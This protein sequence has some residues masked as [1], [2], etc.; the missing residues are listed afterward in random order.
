MARRVEFEVNVD[1]A[2]LRQDMAQAT[3][4]V[5][6]LT[7][8]VDRLQAEFKEA[9]NN[10]RRLTRQLD[11]LE[12][13]G[14][15][16][17]NQYR[18]LNQ[19]LQTNKSRVDSART[20]IDQNARATQQ[21]TQRQRELT[22]AVTN[23][24]NS[25]KTSQEG[26]TRLG[27]ISQSVR[28]SFG[29]LTSQFNAGNTVTQNFSGGIQLIEA[30]IIGLASRFDTIAESIGGFIRRITSSTTATRRA[31]RVQREFGEAAINTSQAMSRLFNSLQAGEITQ[32]QY[33]EQAKLL[34]D[35]LFDQA[36]V[37]RSVRNRFNNFLADLKTGAVDF[38]PVLIGL[39]ASLA[40]VVG[41]TLVGAFAAAGVALSNTTAF[42]NAQT[43]VVTVLGSI[44]ADLVGQVSQ[45]IREVDRA[46][47]QGDRTRQVLGRG[48]NLGGALTPSQIEENEA[49][50][51]EEEARLQRRLDTILRQRR[52][53][54][55]QYDDLR[56]IDREQLQELQ[57]TAEELTALRNRVREDDLNYRRDRARVQVE[58][59]GFERTATDPSA[60]AEDRQEALKSFEDTIAQLNKLDAN[61]Y[62]NK[63]DLAIQNAI[64]D[65]QIG[66]DEIRT[67]NEIEEARFNAERERVGREKQANAAR[68]SINALFAQTSE[69]VNEAREAVE[70]FNNELISVTPGDERS[71]VLTERLNGI[72][73]EVRARLDA[74]AQEIQSEREKVNRVRELNQELEDY[75]EFLFDNA[76][77]RATEVFGTESTLARALTAIKAVELAAQAV[78][79]LKNNEFLAKLTLQRALASESEAVASA[80]SIG[81]PQNLLAIAATVAQFAG[82]IASVINAGRALTGISAPSFEKGG[83][84]PI[85]GKR[86]S[87]GGTK[88]YGEDGTVFEAEAGEAIVLN[89][90][91]TSA[92][93]PL[94]NQA[95]IEHGG[96]S[97]YHRSSY[98]QTGGTVQG[99]PIFDTKQLAR[100]IGAEVLAGISQLRPVVSV[101]DINRTSDRVNVIQNNAR[102]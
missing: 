12:R 53:V 63:S 10:T 85:G 30:G 7:Q 50:R 43:G 78:A 51:A 33:E 86:H 82:I 29:Q 32:E 68:A 101:E 42:L 83:I 65:A 35:E 27:A 24:N 100:D 71:Q 34:T 96:S 94:F 92:L 80:A 26:L 81:F 91:A 17:T 46:I 39:F 58:L 15:Q 23:Y 19:Q 69:V 4:S 28:G 61:Y 66:E 62:Q 14:K 97:L 40:V 2:R 6:K 18:Q 20:A 5:N 59:E 3:E 55:E 77:Q 84:L 44:W 47:A 45:Y 25:V 90:G 11:Q 41:T 38:L 9:E 21:A 56:D 52:A 16:N 102:F 48:G 1:T 37:V 8:N 75:R 64:L 89:R 36:S 79:E 67:I 49:T 57:L 72:N 76:I 98:L 74:N 95:N 99:Q 60:S 88:F 87:A 54:I 13:E 22:T 31:E 70:A 93:M 73:E